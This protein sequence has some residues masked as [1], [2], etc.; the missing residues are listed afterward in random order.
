MMG[1]ID[2]W[3]KIGIGLTAFGV[4]FFGLGV[5]LFFDAALLAFGNIL[6][7]A[8]VVML[9]G[10]ARTLVFFLR[11]DKMRGTI[12]FTLGFL[13]VLMGWVI[14]GLIIEAF[15]FVNLFGD[16]FP[17]IYAFLKQFPYLGDFLD[18]P[19]VKQITDFLFAA[20]SRPSQ[21]P[22]V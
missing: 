1:Y 6:F 10:P 22:D 14:I 12:C 17:V 8:G 15:G 3:K 7:V 11:K 2:D 16:F 21:R 4:L 5:L 9:I 20:S 18:L 19:I 13:L